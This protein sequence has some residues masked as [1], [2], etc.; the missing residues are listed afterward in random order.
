ML[1][2]QGGGEHHLLLGAGPAG[3][4]LWLCQ[5]PSRE[6]QAHCS[7]NGSLTKLYK[8][9]FLIDLTMSNKN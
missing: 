9:F 6:E 3:S 7:S 4:T 1:L 8:L 2:G 5:G